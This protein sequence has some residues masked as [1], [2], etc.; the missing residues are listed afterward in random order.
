[1]KILKMYEDNE[2]TV[3]KK[4]E[5]HVKQKNIS[6]MRCILSIQVARDDWKTSNIFQ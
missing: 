4:R 6:A 3:E 2:S 5:I 1:M